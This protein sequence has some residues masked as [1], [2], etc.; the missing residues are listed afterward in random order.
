MMCC[1]IHLATTFHLQYKYLLSFLLFF[2]SSLPICVV[3]CVVLLLF[4]CGE[5]L[6]RTL[7]Q[8]LQQCFERPH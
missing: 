2:F 7:T 5:M 8:F 6:A 3:V 4:R 1:P